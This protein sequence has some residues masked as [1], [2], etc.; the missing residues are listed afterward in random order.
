[1]AIFFI[2]MGF[3]N[4]LRPLQFVKADQLDKALRNLSSSSF[5][6]I[7]RLVLPATAATVISW[8]ACNFGLFN[9]SAMSDAF[10]LRS[11]TPAPS[12]SW[13]L[14]VKDLF[15]ALKSTWVIGAGNPYD[16]PQW[17]LVFFVQASV[18][19]ISALFLV[20]TMTPRWRSVTLCVLAY[21]SLNWSRVIGDRKWPPIYMNLEFPYISLLHPSISMTGLTF[22]CLSF[23]QPMSDCAASWAS[24]SAN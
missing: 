16:Q 21:C 18:M 9:V 24:R 14:A 17:V 20:I 8:L 4:G 22:F 23:F 1:M 3:L 11:S 5:G 6:Q 10:W 19:I 12:A 7:F 2:L 13:P 15:A